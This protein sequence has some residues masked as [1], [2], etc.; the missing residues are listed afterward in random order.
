MDHIFKRVERC[1]QVMI[2]EGLD[3]L[4]LI[5]D[6]KQGWVNLCYLSGFQGT[7][8]ALLITE[9]EAILTTDSRYTLQA[10]KTSP[11]Q[12]E[13]QKSGVSLLTAASDWVRAFGLKKVGFDGAALS[14]AK[15]LAMQSFGP[16]WVD[17]ASSL[18]GLR[19]TKDQVEIAAIK[20]AADIA[21]YAYLETLPLVKPGMKEAEFAKLVELAIARHD[22]EGV[23]H[24]GGMIVASGVRSSLPHGRAG[25]KTMERGEQVTVDYGSIYHAYQSDITRNFSLGPLAD[26]LFED[27][28]ALLLEAHTA[29]A[30]A[31]KPGVLGC[32]VDRVARDI[33]AAAGYGPNFGHGLG[34]SFGLEIHESPRL[35]PT[36]RE[37]LHV[38][39]VVTIEPG[40]YI[41]D[42]GG[43]R[44]EDDY[45][46]TEDGACRL[47]DALPQEFIHL[48]L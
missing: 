16:Q 47:T 7:S 10:S 42:R 29:A 13:P 41:D 9:K 48:D 35:S 39:D 25:T 6:E 46:I 12:L 26:P 4:I 31:L 27:I 32:D 19:R 34:H 43:L 5:N 18:A 33:I 37:P 1:R 30:K 22:G 23:W 8:G 15:Y 17:F 3:G 20:K 11:L 2:E 40:I 38:G 24:D 44:L 45:L 28:H 36:Y 21:A 14:A